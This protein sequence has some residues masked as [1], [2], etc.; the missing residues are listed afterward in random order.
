MR[1]IGINSNKIGSVRNVNGKVYVDFMYLGE[2]VREPSGLKWNEENTKTVRKQLDKIVVSIESGDFR[3]AEIFPKSKKIDL[4]TA[5]EEKAYGRNKTP[6]Q[7]LFKD[8]VWEWFKL[9]KA[10]EM[11]S[12]RTL[13]GYKGY[14]DNYLFPFF[15]EEP[16]DTFNKIKFD[17]FVKWA[18]EKKYRGK[19]VSNESVRKYFVPLK[20]ICKDAAIKYGWGVTYNPFF[21]F[22]MPKGKLKAYEKINPFTLNEQELII[23]ALP[24]HWKPYFRFAFASGI[25]QGEQI[26]LKPKYIKWQ[27]N[28]VQIE[29]AM[30]LDSNGKPV[31]GPCKNS[32]RRRKIIL[33]PTMLSALE[34]QKLIYEKFN[35]EFFFCN[36]SGKRI[37]PSNLRGG[38]WIPI[39]KKIGIEYREM[40]QTRHSFAT[41]HLSQGKNPLHIAKVM[42]HRNAEMVINVYSK[43]IDNGVSIDE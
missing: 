14:I 43:H 15:A 26:G 8:Y 18:K 40:R 39:F 11:I 34:E 6:D 5:L 41:Y 12:G 31:L 2:R 17:E 29:Y 9:R 4:F 32:Y 35:G 42:G 37:D 13:N 19:G 24:E 36:E 30:T 1:K 25:S 20:M 28:K 10:S 7:V 22:K 23:K 27:K 38:I 3:F 16:F 21:A 33:T